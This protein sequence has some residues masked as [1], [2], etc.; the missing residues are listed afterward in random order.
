[1]WCG[2]V[3]YALRSGLTG[4]GEARHGVAWSGTVWYALRRDPVRYGALRHGWARLGKVCTVARR[5]KVRP[6]RVS[7]GLVWKWGFL[8]LSPLLPLLTLPIYM[9]RYRVIR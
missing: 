4:Y 6:D 7:Y 8:L 5:G 1:M 9:W 3:R 2:A